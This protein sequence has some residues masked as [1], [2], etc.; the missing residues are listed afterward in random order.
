MTTILLVIH[1]I[2]VVAL[3]G[4]ILIQRSSAD[5]MA[6]M[7]GAGGAGF[8]TGRGTAN[9]LT[10]TTAVL[11]TLFIVNSL[12]LAIIASKTERTSGSIIDKIISE[13][14]KPKEEPKA[15]APKTEGEAKPE[16]PF[17]Q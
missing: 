15:E 9:L 11:A 7:G 1:I 3:I 13:D 4:V 16:V 2:I 12:V 14:I 8:M 5:G 6:G 10:R 17:A